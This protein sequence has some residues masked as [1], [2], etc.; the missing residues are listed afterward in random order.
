MTHNIRKSAPK[1]A[2]Y[3]LQHSTGVHYL[4]VEDGDLYL[5][6]NGSWIHQPE[7]NKEFMELHPL[8][9]GKVVYTAVLLL[10]LVP[11]LCIALLG[12]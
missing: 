2:E 11:I 6:F 3:F 5:W 8:N 10:L 9:M 12:K 7:M 1:G 4:K